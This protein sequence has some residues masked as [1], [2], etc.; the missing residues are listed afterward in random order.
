M[1]ANGEPGIW[2]SEL[3]NVGEPNPV[4]ATNP[5]GE[6]ALEAW[7][8]C[9]LGHVNLAAFVDETQNI[10]Y[11]ELDQAH[12]L[13]TRFLMRAT[14]GDVNDS[15]QAATLARNRRIGVGHLGVASFIAMLGERYSDAPNKVWFTMLLQHLRNTVDKAAVEYAHDLR[16]PVPVKKRTVAPTGTIAKLVGV[17]EGIHPIFAKYFLRRIRFSD[18]DAN[19]R[20][21]VED[22]RSRGYQVEP[23]KYAANTTVVTIPTQDILMQEVTDR[24]GLEEA[25][26]IVESVAELSA[27]DM[28]AMQEVYQKYW[29]DNAVSYTVNF[30]PASTNTTDIAKVLTEFGPTLKGTTFF[31]EQS[32]EQSP[33]ERI[34]KADFEIY[35]YLAEVGD[36]TDESCATGACPVR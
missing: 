32:H 14:N 7:E 34:S 1:L 27:R 35:S 24:F 10:N 17:S 26:R 3:S 12:E 30:D 11:V 16:I 13:M 15:K 36:G 9:N 8:N 23:C 33:Y 29:A 31:P 20:S 19:Q 18:V 5:C 21:Q 4:V 25:E 22:Y 6:I 28:L 2:N